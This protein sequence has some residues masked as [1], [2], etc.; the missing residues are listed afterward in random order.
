MT[1]PRLDA[2]QVTHLPVLGFALS[3][4]LWAAL[5]LAARAAFS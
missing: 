2:E 1:T 5:Y 4:C 3:A